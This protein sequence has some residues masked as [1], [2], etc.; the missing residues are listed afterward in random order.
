MVSP[1][2]RHQD[3]LLALGSELR[4]HILK[5]TLGHIWLELDVHLPNNRV[6][7]PDLVFL[8]RAH[9]DRLSPEDGKIHGVP[10]LV[11]EIFSPTTKRRDKTTKKNVYHRAGVPWYWMV[12]A[13]GLLI[14]ECQWKKDGYL[15][16]QSLGPGEPFTPRLFP[17]L[18]IDLAAL[19][20]ETPPTEAGA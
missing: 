3:V 4:E 6:Y 19:L 8:T 13:D 15:L 1:H 11:V 10:D 14:D 5:H 7:I 9:L 2:G 17:A 16:T 20:G 18:T 12:D